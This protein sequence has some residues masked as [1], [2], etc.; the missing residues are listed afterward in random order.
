[1]KRG[2]VNVTALYLSTEDAVATSSDCQVVEEDTLTLE[3]EDVGHYTLMW[4]PT[5]PNT[6]AQGFTPADGLLGEGEQPEGLS[7]ALGFALSEGLIKTLADVKSVSVCPDNNKVIQVQLHHP[8]SVTIDRKNVVI[9]SSCGICGPRDILEDN[10]LQLPVAPD[11]LRLPQQQFARL[12][13][14]MRAGQP[15]FHQTGGS[16]AAAIFDTDG[17]VLAIAEDLGR[18]NALDKVIGMVLLERG[19]LRDCGAVLS[20]R[21]SLEMVLKAA[22]SGLQIM[23]AVSAPTSLAIQVA[24]KFGIT[25][26]GFVREQRATVYSHSQRVLP[27]D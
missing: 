21:L 13:D 14:E 16:H 22:R 19:N 8:E 5:A 23:L 9:N 7:L 10:A 3:V 1:M 6:T 20:S 12:M 27:G 25:L 24:E 18:H 4:T 2:V 11:T 26:C 15:I 17:K